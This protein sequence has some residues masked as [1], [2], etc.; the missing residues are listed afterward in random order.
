M[1]KEG[2]LNV[3]LVKQAEEA[4]DLDDVERVV[5]WLFGRTASAAALKH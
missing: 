2:L 3:L 5:E 1:P 4:F